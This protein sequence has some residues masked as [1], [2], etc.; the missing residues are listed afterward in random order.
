MRTI[1]SPMTNAGCYRQALLVCAAAV[2]IAAP[3]NVIDAATAAEKEQPQTVE[4]AAAMTLT[5]QALTN[6][7]QAVAHLDGRQFDLARGELAQAERL[8]G[9]VRHLLAEPEDRP[10]QRRTAPSLA[11]P[12]RPAPHPLSAPDEN[13]DNWAPWS[14]FDDDD[15]FDSF[16]DMQARM[17][18]L[19][20][21]LPLPAPRGN[22]WGAMSFTPDTDI[23]DEGDAY[24]IRFDVPGVDKA[25]INVKVEGR[26]LTVS[27]KT[28][29]V[30]EEKDK[31]RV[32]RS[33]RR[34][35][36]FQRVITLPG[37]V[38]ADKVEAKCEKGV[39]TVTVPKAGEEPAI[40]N[41][42]VI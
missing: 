37:P 26:V 19:F 25:N 36:Q 32:I 17:H 13:E 3:A 8:L 28:E 15:M 2:C 5:R 31:D 39:L 23:A 24:V 18:Q 10:G 33:E 20:R 21:Q 42:P 38:K 6:L 14:P 9:A 16:C 27:G 34:S 35:G 22:R 40:Q 41:V 12:R 30:S 11:Q 29:S 1:S 4:S 7:N